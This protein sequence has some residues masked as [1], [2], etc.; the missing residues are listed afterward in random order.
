M[1]DDGYC[2]A[3]LFYNA[4]N[5]SYRINDI[6][7]AIWCYE[8]AIA[9]KPNKIYI[10]NLTLANNRIKTPIASINDIFFL[11]WWRSAYML[12]SANAWSIL[13]LIFFLTGMSLL[14]LKQVKPSFKIS[15]PIIP[16]MLS[17]TVASLFF[18]FVRMYNDTYRY[19][20]IVMKP[21]TE[22]FPESK[23]S[24][25]IL[26]EGIKVRVVRSWNHTSGSSISVILPDGRR[27]TTNPSKLKK[28]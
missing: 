4:G 15:Y 25:L 26:S 24:K 14:I 12:F 22:F 8:K 21:K 7:M 11:R 13:A 9:I 3:D 18:M 17:C 16:V 2:S 6:G 28:L 10:D 23:K 5:A 27:G 20:A 19:Y 1:I